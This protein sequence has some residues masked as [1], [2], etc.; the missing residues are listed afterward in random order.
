VKTLVVEDS[1]RSASPADLAHAMRQIASGVSIVTAGDAETGR[2]G[3]T[4]TAVTSLS[5]SPPTIIVCLNQQSSDGVRIARNHSF[6]V[7]VLA[8]DQIEIGERFAAKGGLKGDSP[9]AAG[10]W[11]VGESG[12]PVLTGAL[13]TI[14]CALEEVIKRHTHAILIGRVIRT[15]TLPR[16]PALS[17]W[18]GCYV[19]IDRDE[20]LVRLAEV[21]VPIAKHG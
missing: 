2:T 12:A 11:T 8:A 1:E 6:A 18:Q 21:S 17:Y 5:L 13:A 4:A 14:E 10:T 15:A 9:F 7:N 16:K 19:A 3:V 20:N